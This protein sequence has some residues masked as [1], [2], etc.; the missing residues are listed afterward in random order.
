MQF[1][2]GTRFQ[3]D[4]EFFTVTDDLFYHLSHL[5]DLDGVDDEVFGRVTIFVGRLLKTFGYFLDTIIEN[6]GKTQQ[7]GLVTRPLILS[8]RPM[9][10]P[11]GALQQR[12]LCR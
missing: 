8:N 7:Y 2:F 10:F 9:R 5:V 3:A 4:V 12:A 11:P 6:I 1:G